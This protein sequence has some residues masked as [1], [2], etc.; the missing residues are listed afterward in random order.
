VPTGLHALGDD[1]VAADLLGRDGLSRRADLPRGQCPMGVDSRDQV[2]HGIAV[3]ELDIPQ[4][5][6]GSLHG[7]HIEEGHQHVEANDAG[8]ELVEHPVERRP[9]LPVRRDGP[10]AAGAGDRVGQLGAGNP[11]HAGQLDRQLAAEQVG[12]PR[13]HDGDR[14]PPRSRLPDANRT[15]RPCCVEDI[16]PRPIDGELV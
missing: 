6:R 3:E 16:R 12:E 13:A 11:A 10:G 2:R 15:A 7:A 14:L 1:E 4:P 9:G 5:C 8:P